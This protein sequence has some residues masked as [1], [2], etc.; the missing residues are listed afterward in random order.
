MKKTK[1]PFPWL[2]LCFPAVAIVEACF[3]KWVAVQCILV[4]GAVLTPIW[5]LMGIAAEKKG[6]AAP[7][8]LFGALWRGDWI[9]TVDPRKRRCLLF[10]ARLA[11]PA[12]FVGLIAAR[13]LSDGMD[14]EA[15]LVLTAL[16]L[17]LLFAV[18]MEIVR[19]LRAQEDN[20]MRRTESPKPE[21]PP[22]EESA[23]EKRLRQIGEWLEI[24]LIDRAEY[25]RLK[26]EAEKG[27]SREQ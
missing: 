16:L 5:L 14:L 26:D 1:I 18:A 17:S 21:E 19:D 13:F 6:Q 3:K 12:A 20:T 25:K 7:S 24:G 15:T 9:R 11:L 22:R 23:K 4:I 10:L 8:G 27:V 2:A